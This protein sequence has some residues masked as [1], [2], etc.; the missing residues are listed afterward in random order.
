MPTTQGLRLHA[1]FDLAALAVECVELLRDVHR[2]SRVV[3]DQA[4]DAQRHVG[5]AAGGVEARADH[6]AEVEG[7]APAP[8]R[9]RR[10]E[11]GAQAGRQRPWR[12]ALQALADEDAVVAVEFDDVG[13]GAERDQVEQR[14]E[15]GFAAAAEPAA[16][17][18]FGAQREHDV[19]HDADAGEA[20]AREAQ[21]GWLGFTMQS[22]SGSSS[23]GRWWSVIS[24]AMPSS[25]ARATPST[26]AMPLSTVTMRSGSIGRREVDD[27]GREAVAVGEAVGHQIIDLGAEGAQRAHADRAGGGAVAVV[28]GDDEDACAGLDGVG[29]QDGGFGGVSERAGGSSDL[30]S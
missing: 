25:R 7:A 4:F 10:R 13:D 15:L 12:D 1:R 11:Q 28:V 8:G 6:E 20:L 18:Q 21:P 17:A 2:A 19:E 23:P 29:E 22:A 27:V 9:V 14:G 30:N 5:Q 16:L 3:G 26:L 24:V